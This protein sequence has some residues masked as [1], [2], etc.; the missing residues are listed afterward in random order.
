M[1]LFY[2]LA[3]SISFKEKVVFCEPAAL[4]RSPMM[5]VTGYFLHA[6]PGRLNIALGS[7]VLTPSPLWVLCLG[8]GCYLF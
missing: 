8:V 1:D 4:A 5:A 3:R 7:C 2:T 6:R